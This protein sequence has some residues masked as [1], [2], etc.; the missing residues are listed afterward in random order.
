LHIL[1]W[2]RRPEDHAGHC[3]VVACEGGG[4]CERRRQREGPRNRKR[5]TQIPTIKEQTRVTRAIK[6]Q[7]PIG[8]PRLG[9]SRL[10]QAEDIVVMS[11]DALA[12]LPKF[13]AAIV[14]LPQAVK[15]MTLSQ[16]V[17][18]GSTAVTF[19]TAR[20]SSERSSST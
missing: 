6:R 16:K 17:R 12:A 20:S 4:H 18:P 5:E 8:L 9:S 7:R 15:E 13:T 10:E 14:P 1:E 19:G 3:V 11:R 2:R